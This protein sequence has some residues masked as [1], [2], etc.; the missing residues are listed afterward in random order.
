MEAS[1]LYAFS[2]ARKKP[3]ICIAQITN[4]MGQIE[5]DF[6][7]AEGHLDVLEIIALIAKENLASGFSENRNK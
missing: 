1:A 6:E 5:N 2:E 4:Q 7:K 3:V